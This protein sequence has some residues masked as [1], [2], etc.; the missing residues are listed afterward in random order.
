V[1]RDPKTRPYAAVLMGRTARWAAVSLAGA[2]LLT[3]G[4]TPTVALAQA[5]AL[6][7]ADKRQHAPPPVL[8]DD[9]LGPGDIYVEADEVADDRSGEVVAATGHAE[10]RYQGRTIRA[11]HIFYNTQTGAVRA[12]GRVVIVNPDK[13]VQ[14]GE[15]IL[16]DD[17]L[18]VGVATAFAARLQDNVTIVAGVAVRRNENVNELNH[19]AFT[20]CDICTASGK[21]KAPTFKIAASR[22]IQDREHQVIYYTNAV[23][24]V[25]GL[26]IFYAP[27]FWHA[28]PTAER[29][30]GFLTPRIEIGNKRGVSVETPYLQVLSPSADI[31]LSPQFNST[32]NPLLNLRFR[33]RF[34]SGQIDV[35]AGYTFEKNFDNNFKYD[36]ASSRSYIL[37]KGRFNIDKQWDWGFGAERVTDPSFFRRYSIRDIYSNRGL[38]GSDTFRLITQLFTQRQDQH[39][40]LSLGLADFQSLRPVGAQTVIENGR[41]YVRTLFETSKT[42][43]AAAPLIEAHVDEPLLGGNFNFTGN[44]VALTRE[45]PVVSV[46]DPTG[47]Q[48]AG[49]RSVTQGVPSA[50]AAQLRGLQY[51]NSDRVSARLNWRTSIILPIGARLDPFI[52]GGGD[53]Y[54]FGDAKLVNVDA[55]SGVVSSPKAAKSSLSRGDATVGVDLSYPFVRHD[56]LGTVVLEPLAELAASPRNKPNPNIP[57][58]DSAA[59]ELDEGNLFSAH[60]FSGYDLL[61]SGPRLNLGARASAYISGGRSASLL[62]GRVFRDKIDPDFAKPTG[63]RGT[64]SDWITYATIRPLAYL[65]FFNRARLD[66][67]S[68]RVRREEAGVDV[69][70]Q[71]FFGTLRYNYNQS[72]L[73]Y[74]PN[75]VPVVGRVETAEARAQVFLTKNWGVSINAT[76]DLAHSIWPQAQ[77]GLIYTDECVRLDVIYTHDEILGAKI[78]ASD[79]IGL[80]LTLATLGDQ[81]IGQRR[82]DIR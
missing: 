25:K 79:S 51:T 32:V 33:E 42:F 82:S 39:S 68:W 70:Y 73:S 17:Q 77:V 44:A 63:L 56:S 28:D 54:S 34:Y 30:S 11:D 78:G 22:I 72:G 71:R 40:Y 60:R 9:G 48:A 53:L 7:P 41:P 80:R 29:R 47:V 43:P 74:G 15:D 21:P 3:S 1:Q 62:V 18:R 55:V 61:E 13:T 75:F 10:V 46:F 59:F 8:E 37:A 35:R 4:L 36:N 19:G 23:I 67:D 14:Y 20:P 76:R 31:T 24:L 69:N 57:N 45:N 65:T 16:L 81:P 52:Q 5:Q 12:T 2:L 66:A 38:Y 27:V 6:R 58:E 64:S 26:P 50:S 49:P